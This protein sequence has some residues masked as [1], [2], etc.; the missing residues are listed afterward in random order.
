VT[1][2]RIGDA[3][4]DALLAEFGA[5]GAGAHVVERDDGFV[6]CDA[7][8]SYF[9][10]QPDWFRGEAEGLEHAFGRVLDIG[11]GAG[12]HAIALQ[13]AGLDVTGIDVSQGAVEVCRAR[14]LKRVRETELVT[15]AKHGEQFDT[16]VM[17]G[18]NLGLLESEARSRSVL[19]ALRSLAAPGAVLV[20]SNQDP[21]Q[22]TEPAHL[23]YNRLNETKG[24]LPGQW[25]LRIRRHECTT[26]WFEY[27]YLSIGDL[28][29]RFEAA[30]WELIATYPDDPDYTVVMRRN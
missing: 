1:S 13:N 30:G 26:P 7:G 19:G 16:L 9:L 28:T 29:R 4:G 27:L 15:F 22:T 24:R 10:Q 20:G 14:G 2:P 5:P 21:W 12:R 11:C 23:A 17:L 18:H 25:R 6:R 8:A 3:L